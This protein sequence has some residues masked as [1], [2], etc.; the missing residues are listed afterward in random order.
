MTATKRPR[1]T[2]PTEVYKTLPPPFGR[3]ALALFGFEPN[4]INLNHG[5]YQAP[6]CSIRSA[7]LP[8]PGS[9]GSLPLPVRAF[10]DE[11]TDEVES[12]PDKFVKVNCINYLNRVRERVAKLIGA[13]TDECVIVNNTSHGLA[14]VLRNFI[15]N[16]GDILVG[17]VTTR[18]ADV[19]LFPDLA[20][21]RRRHMVP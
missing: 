11:L 13:E 18:S 16:E 6:C 9:Y 4:Y 10:C 2:V 21:Q 14:T 19:T 3:D 5:T 17:G 15:F 20:T 1:S 12:N 8:L 7:A